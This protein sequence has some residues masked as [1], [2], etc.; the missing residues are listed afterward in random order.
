MQVHEVT[1]RAKRG[2]TA[3]LT[4][5]LIVQASGFATTIVLARYLTPKDFG[6]FGLVSLIVQFFSFFATT[7]LATGVVRSKEEPPR[8]DLDS[9]FTCELLVASAGTLVLIGVSPFL[10]RIHPMFTRQSMPLIQAL[11][12]SGWFYVFRLLPSIYLERHLEFTKIA[13]IE[14]VENLA[15]N[16]AA[17][18]MAFRHTGPWALVAATLARSITGTALANILAPLSVRLTLA[19]PRLKSLLAVGIGFQSPNI[20]FF[21]KDLA[22]PGFIAATLG[23]TY[24]GYFVWLNDLKRK[25]STF[26]ALFTKIAFPTMA[27][28]TGVGAEMAKF[29]RQ[30]TVLLG[31]FYW[32]LTFILIATSSFYIHYI[33]SDK[34]FP[35]QGLLTIFMPCILFLIVI[36]PW[37]ALSNA[38][39]HWRWPVTVAFSVAAWDVFGGILLIKLFGMIGCGAAFL[40]SNIIL[41]C[42][43]YSQLRK[44]LPRTYREALVPWKV[45]LLVN[46]ALAIPFFYFVSH[47]VAHL[48]R[49]L[50][51]TLL[52]CLAIGLANA[53]LFADNRAMVAKIVSHFFP[54]LGTLGRNIAPL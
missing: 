14:T 52:A 29:V 32:P 22:M 38:Q 37:S 12:I 36:H 3:S 51:E 9:V 16:A 28:L 23:P 19:S 13:L 47:S 25:F 11:A 27:R 34:W 49:C 30:S 18:L 31:L 35:A 43:C 6:V 8:V 33:F 24:L 20:I 17:I 21:L 53:F 41:T 10:P 46:V 39:S 7:G 42:L 15:Y 48:T 54:K 40:V 5:Q 2:F 1:S 4:R 50:A 26:A 45:K 44:L